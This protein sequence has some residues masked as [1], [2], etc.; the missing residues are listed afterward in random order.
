L[1]QVDGEY[2]ALR[3]P[4]ADVSAPDVSRANSKKSHL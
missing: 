1:C 4:S 2:S 3:S